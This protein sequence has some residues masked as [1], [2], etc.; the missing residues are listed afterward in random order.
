[1][2]SQIPLS[3]A[4]V[5]PDLNDF[6]HSQEVTADVAC[7]RLS[8]VNVAYIGRP[9][10]HEWVLIDAGIIG[11]AEAIRK[12]AAERF[13]LGASPAAILL[14]HAHFDHVGEL[15]TLADEWDVPIVAHELERPYLDGTRSYPPPNTDAGGGIMS[16]LSRFFPRAPVNVSHRLQLLPPSGEV[17]LLPCWQWIHT[18]G[19]TPG[20]VS[21][22]RESDRLVIAGDAF[23]TTRQESAYAVAVQKPEM[24][25]PPRYFTPD[26]ASARRSVE[27][28]AALEPEIAVTGHGRPMHGPEMRAALHELARNFDRV[29]VP[30]ER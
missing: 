29:A 14:T 3:D 22:W 13:G 26:W 19:H 24:H 17:P 8:L 15:V 7:Q 9:E 16:R 28:L 20:H 11:S 6:E 25:G 30:A 10:T 12:A 18:P 1:M 5:A 4:A 21:F 23:I 27:T 2:D